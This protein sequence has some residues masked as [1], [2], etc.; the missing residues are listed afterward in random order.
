[1]AELKASEVK[2]GAPVVTKL[3]P[4]L[5]TATEI[6]FPSGAEVVTGGVELN[7]E[8]LGLTDAAVLG[9]QEAA[10]PTGATGSVAT[11]TQLPVAAWT[12][13]FCVE[14]T[15]ASKTEAILKALPV[16]ITVQSGKLF[17]RFLE[18]KTANKV[19]LE[20]TTAEKATSGLMALSGCTIFC[21]GK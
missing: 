3:G 11:T 17:L 6:E 10:G 14:Q 8:K 1:M 21:I 13:G 4:F 9:A 5:F 18:C 15:T 2:Y 7:L 16:T 20:V 19:F 12:S